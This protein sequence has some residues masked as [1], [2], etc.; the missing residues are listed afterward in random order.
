MARDP[1]LRRDPRHHDD[2][3]YL[4]GLIY[5]QGDQSWETDEIKQAAAK[6]QEWKQNGYLLEGFEGISPD[7]AVLSSRRDRAQC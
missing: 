4:D 5:R 3:E 2:A 7:D 6:L 1:P